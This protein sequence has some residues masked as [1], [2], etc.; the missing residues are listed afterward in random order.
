MSFMDKAKNAVEKARGTAKDKVGGATGN[1]DLQAEGKSD[2]G[3][4]LAQE[5][6]REREGRLQV[7]TGY[8][9]RVPRS[10]GTRGPPAAP[11]TPAPDRRTARHGP[12][13]AQPHPDRRR[14]ADPGRRPR[15]DRPVRQHHLAPHPA[16]EDTATTPE[17]T[18]AG[19]ETA[20]GAAAA[21][22]AIDPVRRPSPAAAP[23]RS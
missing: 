16:A 22:G 13:Q 15:R 8:G 1:R 9:L 23:V 10:G 18:A 5:R 12:H 20:A 11:K 21:P 6:G 19:T 17:M 4:R 7:L 3:L 2:K 14:G